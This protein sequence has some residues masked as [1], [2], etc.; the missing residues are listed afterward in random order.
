MA[1]LGGISF[2]AFAVGQLSNGLVEGRALTHLHGPSLVGELLHAYDESLHN[3]PLLTKSA[4]AAFTFAVGDLISQRGQAVEREAAER[5]GVALRHTPAVNAWNVGRMA[6]Y[7]SLFDAPLQHAWHNLIEAMLPG[8]GLRPVLSKIAIDQMVMAPLQL[9]V[10]LSVHTVS[11]GGTVMQGLRRVRNAM[12]S[13]FRV[14]TA[15]WCL[16]HCVTFGYVPLEY[17]VV[18][19]TFANVFYVALLSF[20]TRPPLRVKH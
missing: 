5:D 1:T 12:W 19:S 11:G 9:A 2:C 7:G 10:Y 14:H 6:M 4:T 20:L 8:R 3:R 17:R 16:A 13:V 18:W 15:F